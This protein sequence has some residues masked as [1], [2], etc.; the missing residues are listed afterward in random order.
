MPGIIRRPTDQEM[1]MTPV[2]PD[3]DTVGFV[4]IAGGK[5][6]MTEEDKFEK[7]LDKA[8]EKIRGRRFTVDGIEFP[9]PFAR[10][11]AREEFKEWQRQKD[12]A[13]KGKGYMDSDEL[14]KFRKNYSPDWP[15]YSDLKN[16]I[17]VKESERTDKWTKR[18]PFMPVYKVRTY[19]FKGYEYI[20]RVTESE[21]S[22]VDRARRDFYQT[23]TKIKEDLKINKEKKT[24]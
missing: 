1:D 9:V 3:G 13:V 11:V 16:F 23:E 6:E 20:F 8:E 10:N 14:K 12:R 2:G 21:Q 22:A 18:Y 19:R 5:K 17:L 7:D 24:K 4:P 15:K